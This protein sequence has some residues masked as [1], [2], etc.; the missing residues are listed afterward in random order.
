MIAILIIIFR[1]MTN[2]E[3]LL[4]HLKP[5]VAENVILTMQKAIEGVTCSFHVQKLYSTGTTCVL[6][7]ITMIRVCNTF[8]T[9]SL[10]EV[11]VHGI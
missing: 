6:Y 1:E 2:T 5:E 7:T 8:F 3:L 11:L 4:N 9:A 10:L